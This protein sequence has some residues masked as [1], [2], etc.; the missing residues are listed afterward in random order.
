MKK[1]KIIIVMFIF[2]IL[3]TNCK[4]YA[5]PGR[6]DANG[7]HTCRTNCAKWGLNQGEYHCHSGSSSSSS[8]TPNPTP[9][10]K[11]NVATL[12]TLRI[13]NNNIYIED[14]MNYTTTNSKP[15]IFT[16]PM[17]DK[18]SVSVV[19]NDELQYGEN[20]IL[21]DVTAEDGT[22]KEYKLNI[23]LVSNDAT[24]NSIKVN[25][26]S[27]EIND[28]MNFSTTSSEATIIAI[29]NNNNAKVSCD[30]KYKLNVGDNMIL[31]KVEA[32]DGITNKEYVLNIKRE[33]ILSNDIG[34][35]MSINGKNI[36]FNNYESSKI[37]LPHDTSE[38]SIEYELS[39][40]KAKIDL[41]Y[42]KNID[43]GDKIIKFK[44]IAESGKEQEYTINIHRYS[45]MEEI[46]YTIL[47][48]GL[49]GGM[50][51]GTY[52]SSKKLKTKFTNNK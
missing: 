13:D 7:C 8:N 6:T 1:E 16:N 48:V 12:S 25:S 5:H 22:K 45:R 32:E 50:G 42:E 20:R 34:I 3:L 18:A 52:K 27:L 15:I 9:Y 17:S 19:K 11:S 44:V 31:I 30:E 43:V 21:I 36:S 41:D 29:A 26:E 37:Y 23:T 49:I 28:E 10:I 51:F 46:G 47:G 2:V 39:D 38:I 14:E 40:T 4:V 24:L 35:S 33:K